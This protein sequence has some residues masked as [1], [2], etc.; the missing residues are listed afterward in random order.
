M[1]LTDDKKAYDWLRQA[2]HN[3]KHSGVNIWD[4]EYEIIGYDMYMKPV[5]AL[6]GIELLKHIPNNVEDCGCQNDYPDLSTQ[7]V[8]Q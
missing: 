5:D 2:R 4:E 3:G 1:V 8:F 6:L 7:K